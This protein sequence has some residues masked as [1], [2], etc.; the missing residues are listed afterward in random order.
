MP[1]KPPAKNPGK[2]KKPAGKRMAIP[3]ALALAAQKID[4]GE[5]PHAEA[6]IQEVLKKQPDHPHANHLLGILAHRVGRTELGLELIGK[7]I[8]KL[9]NEA[10]FHTNRG[11]MCR[12]LKRLDE[13][14]AH[15]EKAIALDP[16]SATAHSNLGIAY[17]DRKDYDRAEALQKKAQE[18]QP[19]L[20]ESLNNLG[21]IQRGRKDK[22]GAIAYYRQVLE[23]HPKFLESINNLGAMLIEDE[24]LDEAIKT[25][26]S[27]LKINKNYAEA[28]NNIAN[29]FLAKED[30][31]KATAAYNNALRLNPNYPEPLLGLARVCK[32]KDRYDEAINFVKR[33]LELN[34]D[35][36]EAYSLMGDILI[37]KGEYQEC[38][39]AYR[40]ALEMDENL[41]T[42]HLG[43]GQLK[44]E[45]GQLEVAEKTF[46]HCMEISP[47]ELAPYIFMAQARKIKADDP[48]LARLE[49][50][51]EKIDTLPSQKAMS[52]HFALGKAYDDRKDHE[53]AF[54]HFIEGCKIKRAKIQY[55]A[56]NHDLACRNIARFFSPENLEKLRG[57]GNQSDLPIFVLGMPRSGTTLT[58]TIIASH[59][60]VFAAGELHDILNIAN[61]PKPGVKSEGFPRSMQGL[62]P[63]DLTK[64]GDRYIERLKKHAP[65]ARRI[66]DKMPANFMAL[67]LI[68]LMLPNA[69]II[70]VKRNPADICLSAF[71]KNFNNSQL[72]SYDLTE[73][74]RFYV[75]YA[76]LMEHWQK[77]LPAGSFFNIQYEELVADPEA[78]SRELIEFCGLEWNDACLTP[79]KTER[80]VKTASVTQVRQPVYTSSVERWRRYEKFLQ[81][82]M[83]ALGEYAPQA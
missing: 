45:Q 33:S 47:D 15:G 57:A 4:G 54:P 71:T 30:F 60:D 19:G 64:M 65:D 78:K 37:K 14:I 39:A 43:L 48:V 83:T 20:P 38:E 51:A 27:A 77:V 7:A 21:S 76:R 28:H 46:Q 67:G 8:E 9:P 81:P 70:H 11:E 56:D 74:G 62:T 73:M 69:K 29:A 58:E 16:K 22:A 41:L 23:K 61:H 35:K 34:P 55:S 5:L 68:H 32:E 79:H 40:K 12:L 1:T 72:H 63:D 44:V 17:Y 82:L 26:L 31:D 18:L 66:T 24:K 52:L 36:A 59:P 3:Q 80:N 75:D 53:R 50:E 13:A 10:R 42:A 49:K 2:A 25:L 6:I